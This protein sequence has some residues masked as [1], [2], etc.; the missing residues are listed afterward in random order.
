MKLDPVYLVQPEP[1]PGVRMSRR[2]FVGVAL[3]CV[4][5]G[6]GAGLVAG[7]GFGGV[8]T[9][10]PIPAEGENETVPAELAWARDLSKGPVIG[11]AEQVGAFVTACGNWPRDEILQRGLGRLAAFVA[12]NPDAPNRR[13]AAGLMLRHLARLPESGSV[14]APHVPRLRRIVSR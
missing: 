13:M 6:F 8:A 7:R 3:S 14:L 5:A 9:G 2:R 4:G 12:D 11:M 10:S 1:E